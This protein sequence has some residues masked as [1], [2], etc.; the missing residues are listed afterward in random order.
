MLRLFLGN[1]LLVLFLIPF[2]VV[3]YLFLN[4][5]TTY[6]EYSDSLDLGLWGLIKFKLIENYL[7][8]LSGVFVCINAYILNY[9]FNKNGF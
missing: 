3:S 2:F 6:F 5:Q 1:Q 8:W 7:P 9:F 4:F